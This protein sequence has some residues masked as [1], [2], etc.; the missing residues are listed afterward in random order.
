MST[1][2]IIRLYVNSDPGFNPPA[3]RI[4]VWIETIINKKV[5]R[6]RDENGVVD[7][8]GTNGTT[9]D[10]TDLPDTPNNYSGK[11]GKILKVNSTEDAVEFGEVEDQFW[12]T[13]PLNGEGIRPANNKEI[14]VGQ[15]TSGREAVFGYG[16][17]YT[18][19]GNIMVQTF[20][21]LVYTDRTSNITTEDSSKLE[22]DDVTDGNMIY[23]ASLLNDGVDDLIHPGYKL[24]ID[25]ASVLGSGDIIFEFWNGASW[26][27]FNHQSTDSDGKYLSYA[28]E[29]LE[30]TG[31]FQYSFN[32]MMTDTWT[33][34]DPV[35]LG[36]Q[37]YWTRLRISGVITTSPSVD[38]LKLHPLGRT[39][40]NSDGFITYYGINRPLCDFPLYYGL[41]DAAGNSPD[42]SDI[43][44]SDKLDVGMKE[45]RFRDDTTDRSGF[46]VSIPANICTA[47][48]I[49]LK[50][51]FFG[52]ESKPAGDV[53][54]IIRWGLF[55]AGDIMY[56]SSADAPSTA[57]G[58]KSMNGVASMPAFSKGLIQGVETFLDVSEAL[59]EGVSGSEGDH[60]VITFERVGS[61]DPYSG[62]I[63]MVDIQAQYTAWKLGGHL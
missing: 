35:G 48:P 29:K 33:K 24:K 37:H 32:Q 19:I 57:V 41:F 12:E 28:N 50:F 55:R 59:P 53:W 25:T 46:K 47:C 52:N 6:Y 45:N 30:T 54:F 5:F 18:G 31:S 21:G 62:D 38:H 43:Y 61:A 63:V 1:D 20:D 16:D 56:T 4:F 2:G 13:N 60:I 11:A 3:G 22:F 26:E 39:E 58:E 42:N 44:L 23:I 40:I 8:I 34:N 7:D 17:S 49:R 14:A 15:A 36:V 10:F 9:P 51:T 27:E